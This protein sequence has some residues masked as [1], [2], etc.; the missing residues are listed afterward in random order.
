MGLLDRNT[1]GVFIGVYNISQG[2]AWT[3]LTSTDFNDTRGVGADLA[4]GAGLVFVK[5][6]FVNTDGAQDLFW[7]LGTGGVKTTANALFVA[8]GAADE[9]V[10]AAGDPVTTISI[11][12]SG[13]ATTG[14]IIA[15]LVPA[16]A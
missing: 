13:A 15:H 4:F 5:L 11:Q 2:A 12:G 14:K 9:R 16:A 6:Q 10:I 1:D 8:A 3:D 7:T